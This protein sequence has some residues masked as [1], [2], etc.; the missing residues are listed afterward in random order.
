MGGSKEAHFSIV[1]DGDGITLGDMNQAKG[2]I[3]RERSHSHRQQWH[4]NIEDVVGAEGRETSFRERGEKSR[5]AG[6]DVIL[7]YRFSE[8]LNHASV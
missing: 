1:E 8:D 3:A 2:Q 7:Y 6:K 4:V 5:E